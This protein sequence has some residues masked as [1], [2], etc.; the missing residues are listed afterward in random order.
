M[1]LEVAKVL[2]ATGVQIV[3]RPEPYLHAKMYHFEYARGFFRCFV[4]SANFTLGGFE[5]NHEIVAE[6]E[7][8]GDGGVCQREILRMTARGAVPFHVWVAR[9]QPS[10]AKETL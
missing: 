3:I 9:G 6:L 7:G 10:G 5:R 1:S 4:G 2:A 8:S